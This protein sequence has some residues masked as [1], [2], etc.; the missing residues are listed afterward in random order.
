M[1]WTLRG[2][3][4]IGTS[5]IAPL[6][7]ELSSFTL[8]YTFSHDALSC[9]VSG[10]N[11]DNYQEQKLSRNILNWVW[12]VLHISTKVNW[13]TS[14][15]IWLFLV[16]SSK[17]WFFFLLYSVY[18][19]V[20]GTHVCICVHIYTYMWRSKDKMACI[21]WKLSVF[22]GKGG[23]LLACTSQSQLSDQQESSASQLSLC[24][25]GA[26]I[27]DTLYYLWPF[28]MQILA[29]CPDDPV[30]I[31]QRAAHGRVSVVV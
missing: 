5:L 19:C 31:G 17:P 24:T 28:K 10:N 13:Q 12:L 1:E 3:L 2:N 21:F 15:C 4:V 29:S 18:V 9:H 20:C 23:F 26:G 14:C 30:T 6:Q 7:G 27:I 22:F 16:K 11:R 25:P 8:L